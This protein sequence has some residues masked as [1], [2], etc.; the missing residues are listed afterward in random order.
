M[1]RTVVMC[2]GDE[3]APGSKPFPMENDRGVP[4]AKWQAMSPKSARGFA[5][6]VRIS[7]NKKSVKKTS[8]MNNKQMLMNLSLFES[9][10]ART[11]APVKFEARTAI[12]A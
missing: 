2:H 8:Y 7:A 1:M 3:A 9:N 5:S 10:C 4:D 12:A 6:D 11:C